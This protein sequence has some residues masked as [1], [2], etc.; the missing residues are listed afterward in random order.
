[1]KAGRRGE[2]QGSGFLGWGN[3]VTKE[4]KTRFTSEKRAKE[5]IAKYNVAWGTATIFFDKVVF[6]TITL[7]P[8][9]TLREMK[10]AH[11]LI[12]HRIKEY[13]RKKYSGNL[14]FSDEVNYLLER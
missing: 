6:V 13:L 2:E 1:M 14:L 12:I 5:L 7:P 9:M 4:Y 10:Y 11:T 3:I 8:I